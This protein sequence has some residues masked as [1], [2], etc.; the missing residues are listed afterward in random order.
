M[1]DTDKI[2]RVDFSI[3]VTAAG[4]LEACREAWQSLIDSAWGFPVGEVRDHAG[5]PSVLVD[6]D[7]VPDWNDDNGE[8]PN[9]D[10]AE[11]GAVIGPGREPSLVCELSELTQQLIQAARPVAGDQFGDAARRLFNT[12]C[13]DRLGD[14]VAW[15]NLTEALNELD[16]KLEYNVE[17]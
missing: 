14:L 10:L 6:L 2:Y 8:R 9:L 12:A 4:P 13:Q 5:G 1:S 17:E 16:P 3:D 11:R 15:H 7:I